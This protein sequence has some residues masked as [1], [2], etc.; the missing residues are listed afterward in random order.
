MHS[1]PRWE[2]PPR[3]LFHR[4][5]IR[6]MGNSESI[7]NSSLW[8]WETTS[9]SLLDDVIVA[10]PIAAERNVFRTP[11][12]NL[13]Y[14]LLMPSSSTISPTNCPPAQNATQHSSWTESHSPLLVLSFRHSQGHSWWTNAGGVGGGGCYS[15]SYTPSAS[16]PTNQAGLWDNVSR[17]QHSVAATAAEGVVGRAGAA[18]ANV[19]LIGAAVAEEDAEEEEQGM[20]MDYYS[21][22]INHL[23]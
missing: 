21:T 11:V 12:A 7:A 14:I 2:F 15:I 1:T 10:L 22:N 8:D 3:A 5:W 13:R 9:R 19:L 16:Q 20:S 23:E 4:K 18:A 6:M 17:R